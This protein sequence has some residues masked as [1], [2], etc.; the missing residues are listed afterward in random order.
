MSTC[1]WHCFKVTCLLLTNQVY[2]VFFQQ[3]S[4][5]WVQLGKFLAEFFQDR[6]VSMEEEE[7]RW[8]VGSDETQQIVEGDGGSET[9][10][11]WQSPVLTRD[12]VDEVRMCLLEQE[13]VV[14]SQKFRA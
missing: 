1:W 5:S 10:K 4:I 8:K 13:L 11:E 9:G 7:D 2:K 14:R 12:W 6:Q 3:H